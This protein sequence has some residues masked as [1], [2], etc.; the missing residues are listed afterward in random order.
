MIGGV[1]VVLLGVFV[2]HATLPGFETIVAIT[3]TVGFWTLL[4]FL[5][6]RIE[7]H[8]PDAPLF[9][10]VVRE[11]GTVVAVECADDCE[12]AKRVLGETGAYDVRD[13][14]PRPL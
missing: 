12:I 3:A 7:R 1:L 10:A 4:G 14:T 13:E 8:G 9:E 5:G 2:L 11:G 6:Q